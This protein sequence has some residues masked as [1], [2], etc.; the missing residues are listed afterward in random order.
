MQDEDVCS[1]ESMR[2][3]NGRGFNFPNF[4]DFPPLGL[5]EADDDLVEES[6]VS[7]FLD[8]IPGRVFLPVDRHQN[9]QFVVVEDHFC[10]T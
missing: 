6:S 9:G 10:Q 7:R 3:R 1:R 5:T 4:H 2:L 8:R